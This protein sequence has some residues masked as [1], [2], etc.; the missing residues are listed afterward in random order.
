MNE[1]ST[2]LQVKYLT[3]GV[4]S[5]AV[6]IVCIAVLRH[7]DPSEFPYYPKC[8]FFQVTGLHCPGCGGTRALSALAQGKFSDALRN[9]A[10]LILGLPT[11]VTY[12]W[13]QRTRPGGR[14]VGTPKISWSIVVV[15]VMFFVIRNVP[16]P[17][18]S[19]LA[20]L[21]TSVSVTK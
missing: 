9:N 7:F 19:P 14:R 10:L 1:R 16:S 11:I 4:T 6:L 17:E 12:L 3:V 21:K 2:W 5:V 18:R 13:F 20:P 8:V 15:V